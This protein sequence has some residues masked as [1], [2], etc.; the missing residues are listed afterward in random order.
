[1][2]KPKKME[3]G[4]DVLKRNYES[5]RKKYPL[6]PFQQLNEEFEIERIADRETDMLLREIRKAITEKSI[7][8]LRFVELLLNPT[9]APFFMF[10]IIKNLAAS[11]KKIIESIYQNLCDFEIRAIALDMEYKEKTEAEY[12]KYA[13]KKWQA[14]H[15]E[16]KEL[17]HIIAKAWHASSEKKERNYFG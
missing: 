9:N 10:G 14:M 11:D 3:I 15:P 6:P 4:L 5:F 13:S 8:F 16:M 12:I 17:S 7:A 2:T 1:M